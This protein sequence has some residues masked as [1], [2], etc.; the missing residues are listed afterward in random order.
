MNHTDKYLASWNIK[1]N[2]NT[3]INPNANSNTDTNT[4]QWK[5]LPSLLLIYIC[6]VSDIQLNFDLQM[7]WLLFTLGGSRVFSKVLLFFSVSF[8]KQHNQIQACDGKPKIR[9]S[10]QSS[11]GKVFSFVDA[12]RNVNCQVQMCRHRQVGLC[13]FKLCQQFQLFSF[14]YVLSNICFFFISFDSKKMMRIGL[15]SERLE[16]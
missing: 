1:T 8:A 12:P 9:K 10:K 16:G 6:E 11:K 2:T 5:A 3:N 14:K 15:L 4:D 7:N 13:S